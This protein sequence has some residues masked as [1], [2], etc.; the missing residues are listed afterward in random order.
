MKSYGDTG[1]R[2]DSPNAVAGYRATIYMLP[3]D[4][5]N[6]GAQH[7]AYFTNPLQV[8]TTA[9]RVSRLTYLPL[10]IRG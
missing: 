5:P 6:V 9:F 1:I 7:S 2:I 10:V 8:E 3:A 4:Q